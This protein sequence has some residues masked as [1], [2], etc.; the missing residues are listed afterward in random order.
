MST[1]FRT[2]SSFSRD[3]LLSCGH[4]QMFGAGN[5]RLPV[6]NMLMFD[7]I[8]DISA[9]GGSEGKGRILAELDIHPA[10]WFFT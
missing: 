3:D 8:L 4:G 10:L 2:R 5:A 6:G 1:D 9:T 7:R